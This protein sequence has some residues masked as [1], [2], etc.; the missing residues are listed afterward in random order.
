[1][2]S[3]IYMFNYCTCT[4]HNVKTVSPELYLIELPVW[5]HSIGPYPQGQ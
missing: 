1:M 3:G 4:I 5:K 2:P